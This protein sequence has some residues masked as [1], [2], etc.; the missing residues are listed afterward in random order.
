MTESYELSHLRILLQRLEGDDAEIVREAILHM[1]ELER[2]K[3]RDDELW[4]G[5]TIKLVKE[6][7]PFG[8][9]IGGR[10]IGEV[11]EWVA[12]C[13]NRCA[14]FGDPPCWS[15]VKDCEPCDDCRDD[16]GE[17]S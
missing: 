8:R 2:E 4:R 17:V 3:A 1:A 7:A 11:A 13:A 10:P 14:E 9:G 5:V 12:Q 15:V 6:P 16:S